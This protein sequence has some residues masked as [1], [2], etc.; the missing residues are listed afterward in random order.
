MANYISEEE[1]M[2]R[3]KKAHGDTYIYDKTVFFKLSLEVVI[4]CRI[5][6]DFKQLAASHSMGHGCQKCFADGVGKRS[7]RPYREYITLAQER[8][9]NKYEYCNEERYLSLGSDI[10]FTCP[11]HGSF[12]Q[13]RS[14]HLKSAGCPDCKRQNEKNVRKVAKLA[15]D[16]IK[17]YK[18]AEVVHEIIK[19]WRSNAV[20]VGKM[21][22]IPN[23]AI[24]EKV[25]NGFMNKCKFEQSDLK[26][27]R[28][29]MFEELPMGWEDVSKVFDLLES[30]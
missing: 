20:A 15:I 2:R 22:I 30:K 4:T 21:E 11:D 23:I 1:F 16:L 25:F 13:Q 26:K 27:A 29:F 19:G 17:L 14:Y 12:I 28:E 9:G 8:F 3:C 5:H 10:E 24:V 18:D 7:R 6:G